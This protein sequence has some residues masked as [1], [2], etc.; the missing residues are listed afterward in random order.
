MMKEINLNL[1]KQSNIALEF[2][3]ILPELLYDKSK[4]EI[5]QTII[6]QGNREIILSD[7]CEIRVTGKCQ[8]PENC[9]IK[10]Y[11][12]LDRIKRIGYQ[13][14][15]GQIE[16]HGNVDFHTGS[17]MSG[18]HLTV[19]GDAESYAGCE[20]TGG[21]LE[22]M[23]NTKEFCGSS[24]PGEWRGMSGG[25]IIVHGNAGKQLAEFMIGGQIT[26]K[27]DCD[28]LAGVHMAGGQ[29]NIEG[30]IK[31]WYGGQMKRGTIIINKTQE[32][33]LPGFILEETIANPLINGKY[34][35]GKYK[36]YTGDKGA[37]GKGQIWIKQ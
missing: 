32:K 7:C 2:D 19:Y 26:V 35:I 15:C 27:G 14:S 31:Q 11:G 3:N 28:I 1:K 29:I 33:I 13:M 23:G 21:L 4:Q 18:G 16:A 36:L 25:K 22:I 30:K 24:Y 9:I 5:G 34:Y 6:Y 12:E 17:K 8:S 20:M 37:K 10:I